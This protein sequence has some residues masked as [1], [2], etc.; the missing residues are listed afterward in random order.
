MI[1]STSGERRE[2][3]TKAEE[4]LNLIEGEKH[5]AAGLEETI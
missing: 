5:E 2:Q 4:V 3:A 1:G